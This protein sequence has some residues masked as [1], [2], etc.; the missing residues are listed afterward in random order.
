[1]IAIDRHEFHLLLGTDRATRNARI[2]A[3][4]DIVTA[5]RRGERGPVE[6]DLHRGFTVTE[7]NTFDWSGQIGIRHDDVFT[8]AAIVVDG[9]GW[10]LLNVANWECHTDAG[11]DPEAVNLTS[12]AISGCDTC[13]SSHLVPDLRGE[14]QST[15]HSVAFALAVCRGLDEAG[16]VARW[17]H[18]GF[19]LVPVTHGLAIAFG[20][21]GWA[22]GMWQD[23]NGDEH[24]IAH[25]L[26][27]VT[28]PGVH[29]DDRV[30]DIVRAVT[31][32]LDRHDIPNPAPVTRIA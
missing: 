32:W 19:V 7:S 24:P 12:C 21:H 27:E 28:F 10:V 4:S 13:T 17:E 30:E 3:V 26:P 9:T 11:D 16:R 18:P 14:W 22:D 8:T 25:L 5:A 31:R 29:D 15:E 23:R 1:M 2:L 20:Q 6:V